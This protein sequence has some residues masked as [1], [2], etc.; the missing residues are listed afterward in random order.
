[1]NQRSGIITAPVGT[2]GLGAFDI[3][4]ERMVLDLEAAVFGYF[5][6][7]LLDL[8]VDELFDMTALHADEMIMMS[9]L[10]ELEHGFAALKV[11]T[12]QQARLLKLGENAVDRCEPC[13]GALPREQ[14]VNLLGRE[15]PYR[16]VFEQLQNAQARKRRFE[17][18]CLE[19]VGRAHSGTGVGKRKRRLSY[20][21]LI[22]LETAPIQGFCPVRAFS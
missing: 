3:D 22:A 4:M 8:R 1:M 5:F 14:P 13:F 15:V 7:P 9:A 21:Y 6:L 10:I 18:Y 12:D 19:I 11:M 17:S 2:I 16:A 20:S